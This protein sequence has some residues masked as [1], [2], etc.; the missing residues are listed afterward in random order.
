[1]PGHEIL[2]HQRNAETTTIMR[3]LAQLPSD[4]VHA[5]AHAHAQQQF[6]AYGLI[7]IGD[8]TADFVPRVEKMGHRPVA[9]AVPSGPNLSYKQRKKREK[10]IKQEK[11]QYKELGKAD[12]FLQTDEIASLKLLNSEYGR[13]QWMQE[14]LPHSEMT[15]KE[16]MDAITRRQDYSN[17][18]NLDGVMRNLVA[19][20]ELSKFIREYDVTEYSRPKELC[21]RIY[22][23]TKKDGVSG[24]LNP[25]LRLGLSI[26]Q[27]S[28]VF[29]LEMR[30]IFRELDDQMSAKV[31]EITLTHYADELKVERHL[32]Q[33]DEQKGRVKEDAY[34]EKKAQDAIKANRAQ[35]IQIAKRLLLVQMS[36]LLKITDDV[37]ELWNERNSTPVSVLF[38]HC[39]RAT[40]T[41]PMESEKERSGNT[42]EDHKRMWRAITTV[43]G[44]NDA[45]DNRRGGSTHSVERRDAKTVGYTSKEKKVLVNMIGQRGMN[46]A[47]GGLGNKGISGK[48][49][50]NDGS[51]GHFYS[52]YKEADTTHNGAMLLGLESD[53]H[54]VTN[55]MGHTHDIH[56]TP[57]KAS[58]LG[59]QRVDEIGKKYGGRQ[60]NLTEFTAAEIAVWMEKL[61]I[62]MIKA[63]LQRSGEQLRGEEHDRYDDIM[64]KL[65]GRK[66]SYA[67]LKDL[68]RSI[69]AVR[70]DDIW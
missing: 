39:S 44:D 66:L 59:G 21:E 70:D 54:G 30:K 43:Q 41:L 2:H 67:G 8:Y 24:L 10:V 57:E 62:F 26:A 69:G 29:S 64:K 46:C 58:S 17:F 4:E 52:M 5:H 15:R 55:Q 28:G 35:Q 20:T 23:N 18:E 37:T 31:M 38:S 61:E 22:E 9:A 60:C 14:K 56:A 63:H 34:Y 6:N 51:C 53:A 32:K 49:L 40:L 19:S 42:A 36:E 11:E 16:T 48:M 25:G 68:G 33:E 65:T 45:Q 47:I 27:R 1:M 50:M 7:E 12:R 3:S 13:E